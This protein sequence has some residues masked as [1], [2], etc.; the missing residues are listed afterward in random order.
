MWNDVSKL[1]SNDRGWLD[2]P[3]NHEDAVEMVDLMLHELRQRRLQ[4]LE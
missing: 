2:E 1:A 4:R 3:V